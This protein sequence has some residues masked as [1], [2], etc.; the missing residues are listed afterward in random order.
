MSFK[1]EILNY[2]K[3]KNK[4]SSLVVEQAE[5]IILL[6]EDNIQKLLVRSS[7]TIR[8]SINKNVGI[9]NISSEG[10]ENIAKYIEATYVIEQNTGNA[11]VE[12]NH[13]EWLKSFKTDSKN[14]FYYWDRL[15]SF[16]LKG[17]EITPGVVSTL[18]EDTDKIIDLVGNPNIDGIWPRTGMVLGSVQSGKTLN[19]SAVIAKAADVGYKVIVLLAGI[20]NSLRSQT[21]QRIDCYFVGRDTSSLGAERRKCVG[22]INNKRVPITLTNVKDDFSLNKANINTSLSSIKEPIIFVVKKNTNT[23][24]NLVTFFNNDEMEVRR[25]SSLL[26][27]DDEADNASINTKKDNSETTRINEGIRDILM[28]F[29][30]SSYLGYTATPFANIFID[31]DSYIEG[32]GNDLFPKDYIYALDPPNN[33]IGPQQIFG[34]E[35]LATHK[36]HLVEIDDYQDIIPMEHKNREPLKGIPPSLEEAVRSFIITRAIFI[37]KGKENKNCT[38][39]INVSRFNFMQEE[40]HNYVYPYL[41]ELKKALQVNSG[42][43][44]SEQDHYIIKSFYDLFNDKFSLTR[45]GIKKNIVEENRI[46]TWDNIKNK[47]FDA[48]STI[49]VQTVNMRS[50]PL[51]YPDDKKEMGLHVIAIGGIALSR[52]LTLEGLTV[53]Y[54]LRNSSAFDI[55]M[56]MGRWFGYRD[57]YGEFCKLYLPEKSINYYTDITADVIELVDSIKDMSEQKRTPKDFGLKV[58]DHP[59]VLRITAANKMR[60]SRKINFALDFSGQRI[61]VDKIINT[62][63]TNDNNRNTIKAFISKIGNK[64]ITQDID[65]KK[66]YFWT[67]VSIKDVLSL[68]DDFIYAPG[69]V[70][71]REFRSEGNKSTI[72]EYIYDRKEELKNW[73]IFLPITQNK[74]KTAKYFEKDIIKNQNFPVRTRSA[75]GVDTTTNIYSPSENRQVE[76]ADD[77]FI[78]LCDGEE[79][80][81]PLLIIHVMKCTGTSKYK[82]SSQNKPKP[83]FSNN[84]VTIGIHFPKRNAN[85]IKPVFKSYA[86]NQTYY[87]QELALEINEIDENDEELVNE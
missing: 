24:K 87:Q 56:Q 16:L 31:P 64:Y 25:R 9:Y 46:I 68:I 73:D 21:Q 39:M 26:V 34:E 18:D 57:G 75:G 29:S 5:N 63:K 83:V 59:G 43:E 8:E 33:Y 79:R 82:G 67:D 70:H 53:S 28:C 10:L 35:R 45:G 85:S 48:V 50:S 2:L 74:T 27:I 62:Q 49:E 22:N 19:Y 15:R 84:F 14:E 86:V 78:G 42:L 7:Q 23:L 37:L 30:K 40:V 4:H 61:Q 13:K 3:D 38:M 60:T 20:T 66:P 41:Q 47:L 32:K 6:C 54:V 69:N 11:V 17:D 58:R 1:E 72:Y 44:N 51:K 81:K 71:F 52:G 36:D 65:N 12:K 55:V 80:E 76:S 77:K